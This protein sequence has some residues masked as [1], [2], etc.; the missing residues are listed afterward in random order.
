VEA[1]DNLTFRR[2]L[3]VSLTRAIEE[4]IKLR[5]PLLL[6]PREEADSV[7]SGAL[8]AFDES[9]QVK[10]ETDI[11]L[12]NRVTARVR[13][14]WR[15]RLAGTDIVPQRETSESVRLA[16]EFVETLHDAVFRELAQR[17]VQ[18]MEEP[19]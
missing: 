6:A 9:T 4:E 2:G 5:T 16:G 7:L 12:V 11:V 10:S 3:E 1:F 8:I 19:W 18:Q 17:I 14:R 13:Y 15:D